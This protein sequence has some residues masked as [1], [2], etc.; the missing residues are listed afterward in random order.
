M[1]KIIVPTD[2]SPNAGKALNFAVEIAKVAKASVLLVHVSDMVD[3]PFRE[4]TALELKYNLPNDDCIQL[5]LSNIQKDIEAGKQF[6]IGTKLYAGHISTTIIQAAEENHADM[7]IMGTLGDAAFKEKL[8]GSIT[9]AVIGKSTIPVLAVPIL[10][11]WDVPKHILMVVNHFED[12]PAMAKPAI[13]LAALFEAKVTVVV[14]TDKQTA[15]PADYL[16]N[17]R[18]IVSYEEKLKAAFNDI[19]LEPDR[20]YGNDFVETLDEYIDENYIDILVML[21]HK[22]NLTESLFHRSMTKK[23]SYHTNTPLLAIP[24]Q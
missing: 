16:E 2:F 18:G 10:S 17:A 14:F 3:I 7:I 13:E 1:K 4:K 8:F 21:T 6:S 12:D 23:M 9:A 19:N 22:R 15:V 20:L 11:E 5:E 24:V